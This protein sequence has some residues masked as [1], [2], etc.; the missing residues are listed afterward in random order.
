[1]ILY[2]KKKKEGYWKGQQYNPLPVNI[3]RQYAPNYHNLITIH[4][5]LLK[6]SF[7]HTFVLNIT[8]NHWEWSFYKEAIPLQ[9]NNLQ[10]YFITVLFSIFIS[11]LY[12]F[13]E[14]E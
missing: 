4:M 12:V 11:P 13:I 3:L 8:E 5:F 7:M 6:K 10:V 9:K 14:F 2:L 1:M